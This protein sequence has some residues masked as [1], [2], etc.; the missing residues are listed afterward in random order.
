MCLINNCYDYSATLKTEIY[1]I[2]VKR[3]SDMVLT[4]LLFKIRNVKM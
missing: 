3:I 1:D 2:F 4:P